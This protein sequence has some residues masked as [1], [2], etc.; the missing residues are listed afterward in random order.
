MIYTVTLNPALDRT[1]VVDHLQWGDVNRVVEES[2]F[3]GGKGIDVSRA[4]KELG[5]ESVAL[6]F[7]G[8]YGGHEVAGRLGEEGVIC[9]FTPIANETRTNIIV[10]DRSKGTV[11]S[12]N[13]QGPH[14]AP[15]ELDSFLQHLDSLSPPPTYLVC[16]GS[17]PPGVPPNIYRLLIE[18]A[19]PR[20]VKVILDADGAPLREGIEAVPFAIKPNRRELSGLVG[21]EMST[22][23]EVVV[24]A[25]EL[26]TG[27]IDVVLVS[28]GPDGLV[29]LSDEGVYHAVPPRVEV[30]SPVGAGDSTVAGFLVAKLQGYGLAESVRVATAAGTAATLTSGTELCR[31]DDVRR[32]EQEVA[33][34]RL[35]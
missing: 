16:S 34:T 32:L 13:A 20:A 31:N 11:T 29:G 15:H 12:I 25:R 7:I 2:R 8:G 27:G 14:I 18:W 6:G 4:L 23:E 35:N 24:S 9:R 26:H 10:H 5:W 17:I 22:V 33:V 1:L 28:L 30:A 21:K 3:A 19:R